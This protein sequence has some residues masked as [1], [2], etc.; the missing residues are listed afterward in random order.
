MKKELPT[1]TKVPV[2]PQGRLVIPSEIRR[3][4]GIAPGDVLIA[5]VE[6]ERLVLEKRDVILQRL[7]RRFAH[8]PP[9]VSLADELISERRSESRREG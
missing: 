5:L 1:S 8:I 6:D 7:R 3:Q 9:G 4:L 2:G